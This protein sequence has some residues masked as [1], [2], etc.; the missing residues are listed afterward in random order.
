MEQESVEH[1]GQSA[2]R[3]VG[4]V[5]PCRPGAA[6]TLEIDRAAGDVAVLVYDLQGRGVRTLYR[7]PAASGRHELHWDGRVG[8][9]SPAASGVYH[10][11]ATSGSAT[12][13][14]KFLYLH[15]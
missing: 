14:A 11:R 3:L 4:L 6:M 2:L 13:G 12:A 9:G 1:T 5:N 15:G 7:G 10:L 8:N